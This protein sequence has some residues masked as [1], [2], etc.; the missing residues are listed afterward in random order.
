MECCEGEKRV[1]LDF[2]RVNCVGVHNPLVALL[3]RMLGKK[4]IILW[5]DVP[6]VVE[7]TGPPSRTPEM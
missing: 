1:R 6:Q 5:H 3:F 2:P 7:T 4:C